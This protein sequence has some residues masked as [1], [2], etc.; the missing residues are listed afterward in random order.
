MC[1]KKNPIICKYGDFHIQLEKSVICHTEVSI[2][3]GTKA[4]SHVLW[5]WVRVGWVEVSTIWIGKSSSK[6]NGE[7]WGKWQS[8]LCSHKRL[9]QHQHHPNTR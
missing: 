8:I 2:P 1:K 6:E 7:R 9:K 3:A 5:C 4:A